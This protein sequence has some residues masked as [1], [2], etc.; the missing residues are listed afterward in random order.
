MHQPQPSAADPP[1]PPVAGVLLAAGAG[2]RFGRPKALVEY[3]GELLVERAAAVLRDGG[4]APVHVVVGAE[5]ER[6]RTQ[7]RLPGCRLVVNPDWPTGM[8]S[9]LRAGLASLPDGPAAA[10]VTL[11]DTPGVTAAAVARLLAAHADG[12][13]LAAAGYAGRRGHPVLLGRRWWAEAA[14]L[15]TGDR[16][17]RD[18]LRAHEDELRL[19][20]CGRIAE[21]TDIDTVEDLRALQG[22]AARP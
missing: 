13:D 4:C 19:V 16:G 18:L 1:T 2:R 20:E 15:A 12:A 21:P 22:R 8:A 7:A 10:L 17:A 3:Q 11:V 14:T 6:I 5:A 9:S